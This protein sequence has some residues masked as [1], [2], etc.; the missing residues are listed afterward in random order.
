MIEKPTDSTAIDQNLI[1]VISAIAPK[2]G[3]HLRVDFEHEDF[4]LNGEVVS[5]V[6]GAPVPPERMLAA[7]Q[8]ARA[9]G[10]PDRFRRHEIEIAEKFVTQSG[11][12][13][14]LK[15]HQLDY[16]HEKDAQYWFVF[17]EVTSTK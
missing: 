5:C 12:Y 8:Q 16:D 4:A 6:Q 9:R 14:V 13:I 11:D 1:V 17:V 2:R 3:D 7:N 15:A 10:N